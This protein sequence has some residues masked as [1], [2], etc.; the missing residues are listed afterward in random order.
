MADSWAPDIR[1]VALR[2]FAA[3]ITILNVLGHTVLGFEQSLAQ[4]LAALGVAY[5]LELLFEWIEAR[6]EGRKPRFLASREALFNFLLPPHISALAC[7]MLLMPNDHFGPFIFAVSV[8]IGSKYLFRAPVGKSVRHFLNPSN[9]GITA[10]LLAFHWVSVAP[11]YMFTENLS[12]WQDWILP[13]IIVVSGS[14]LNFK[15]TRRVPLILGWLG[16]FA[17]QAMGR[18][19]LFGTPI[20]AGLT[21]MT[22][23]AF[24][25]FTF[26]M[27]TDPATTPS[28]PKRQVA[29]GASVAL[30]YGVLMRVH[31]VFAIF[32]ALTLVCLTR[33]FALKAWAWWNARAT[34]RVP[35]EEISGGRN[36]P[37]S[38]SA[39]VAVGS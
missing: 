19:L 29:F 12:G 17:L 36:V 10:T 38:A 39:R 23:V 27:V 13:P 26:Y 30:V 35:A 14:F 32:F 20:F 31:V 22:G 8:A 11:P 21:P 24:L 16:A 18:A 15:L 34:A 9:T 2:R 3:A 37:A 28:D 7:S 5:S 4:P 6:G 25:L 33:G 1:I